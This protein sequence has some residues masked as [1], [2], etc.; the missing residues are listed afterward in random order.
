M[1]CNQVAPLRDVTHWFV[2]WAIWRAGRHQ[3]ELLSQ[4]KPY[5][6]EGGAGGGRAGVTFESSLCS[7]PQIV[8]YAKPL[9]DLLIF[10]LQSMIGISKVHAPCYFSLYSLPSNTRLV[11]GPKVLR[12]PHN[13]KK[14]Q[15]KRNILKLQNE[16]RAPVLGGIPTWDLSAS[17][18]HCTTVS[19]IFRPLR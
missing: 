7:R 3:L 6:E 8:L 1:S 17:V 11:S 2:K 14:T 19:P 18:D 12:K 15:K 16:A 9:P 10:Y 4:K 5:L 13:S